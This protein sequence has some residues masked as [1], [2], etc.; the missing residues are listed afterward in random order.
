MIN[1]FLQ[2]GRDGEA[3]AARYLEEQGYKILETN[4]RN[5]LGE[6]DIIAKEGDTYCFVEVKTREGDEYGSPFEA[7]NEYKQR[8]IHRVALRY[9]QEFDLFDEYARF[10][11]VAVDVE[12]APP[13]VELIRHAFDAS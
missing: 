8:Q 4:Y 5:R 1:S 3:V 2:T 12:Q 10:D 11:V 7:V 9:I 13:H 6:I